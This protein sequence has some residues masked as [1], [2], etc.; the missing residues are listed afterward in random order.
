MSN[1]SMYAMN[2]PARFHTHTHTH[3]NLHIYINIRVYV[4]FIAMA[5][6][7]MP[8]CNSIEYFCP[9]E[10]V[11]TSSRQEYNAN[12]CIVLL[13]LIGEPMK[14]RAILVHI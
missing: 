8:V 9:W 10:C 14:M 12:S 11:C 5:A 3:E 13:I 4:L 6:T 7:A 1:R 2:F